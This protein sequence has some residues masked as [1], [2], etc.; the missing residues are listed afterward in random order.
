[1]R[2]SPRSHLDGSWS[3]AG[4]GRVVSALR[5]VRGRQPP[6]PAVATVSK[7]KEEVD[8]CGVSQ[9]C[10]RWVRT[11][12]QRWKAVPQSSSKRAPTVPLPSKS[13]DA[14]GR[15]TC[16]RERQRET[17]STSVLQLLLEAGG[18]GVGASCWTVSEPGK[19]RVD[20]SSL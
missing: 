2:V 17:Q 8:V 13:Q 15:H 7:R 12:G 11:G 19:G 5:P 10:A 20:P 4:G 16:R 14:A 1:M 9:L 6:P 3:L 18:G